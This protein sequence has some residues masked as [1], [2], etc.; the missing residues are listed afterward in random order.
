MS[1]RQSQV[2]AEN[3]EKPKVID[4][5]MKLASFRFP[6]YTFDPLDIGVRKLKHK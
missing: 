3:P 6:Q 2:E 1:S 5:A 4:D